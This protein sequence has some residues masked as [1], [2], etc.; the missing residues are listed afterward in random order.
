ML[1][2][3]ALDF[4]QD[5]DGNLSVSTGDLLTANG[6]QAVRQALRASVLLIKGEWFADREEG[7]PLFESQT[8]TSSEAI[9]GAVFN[10]NKVTSAVKSALVSTGLVVTITSIT[11]DKPIDRKLTISYTVLTV[12]GDT[13]IDEVTSG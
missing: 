9:I 7:M 12:F 8:V 13:V 10:K 5:A 2:T 4:L 3:D 6:E 1:A 11:V